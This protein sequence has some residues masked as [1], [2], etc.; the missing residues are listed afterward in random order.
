MCLLLLTSIRSLVFV[1]SIRSLVSGLS[2]LANGTMPV[3][4]SV[5]AIAQ[6]F[7][8]SKQIR[9]QLLKSRHQHIMIKT[10]I[11]LF[12]AIPMSR[13]FRSSSGIISFTESGYSSSLCT[14]SF[15]TCILANDISI[16]PSIF[17]RWGIPTLHRVAGY[18]A[19]I[20]THNLKFMS[21]LPIQSMD[22]LEETNVLILC[23]IRISVLAQNKNIFHSPNLIFRIGVITGNDKP[24]KR[25]AINNVELPRQRFMDLGLHFCMSKK[26]FTYLPILN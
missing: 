7:S 6:L 21:I 20:K 26:S 16:F 10:T 18:I 15:T 12:K 13:D 4:L 23:L 9:N 5:V 2:E 3:H 17:T 24:T 8:N 11:C 22:H 25:N 14:V 19:K 1:T